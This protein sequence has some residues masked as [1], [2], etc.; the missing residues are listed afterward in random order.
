MLF[1]VLVGTETRTGIE[2]AEKHGWHTSAIGGSTIARLL[3]AARANHRASHPGGRYFVVHVPALNI[4]FLGVDDAGGRML[5]AIADDER[6]PSLR[7]G[8]PVPAAT[9]LAALVPAAQKLDPKQS[10]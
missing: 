4:Y 6:F 7:A 5:I 3:E 8:Q 9:A 1:P 10:S 2:V